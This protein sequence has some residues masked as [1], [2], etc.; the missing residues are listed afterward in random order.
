M[1]NSEAPSDSPASSPAPQPGTLIVP[2]DAPPPAP[3]PVVAPVAAPTSKPVAAQPVPAPAKPSASPIQAASP[4]PTV[5]AP[6]APAASPSPVVPAPLPPVAA[7]LSQPLPVPQPE[8]LAE[9]LA[10][11]ESTPFQAATDTDEDGDSDTDVEEPV[12][13]WTASE[14]IAHEKSAGWYVRLGLAALLGAGLMFLLT[15]DFVSVAVVVVAA[16]LLGVYGSH[17]PRELEYRLGDRGFSI[18]EKV[19]NYDDFRSFSIVP[20]GAFSSIVLLPLKRFGM[21]LTM[22]YPPEEEE[23]IVQLLSDRLPLEEP[24]H[25]RVDSLMRRIRF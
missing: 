23:S 6:I 8:T 19:Y 4:K 12:V 17:K 18:A 16:I 14:F 13:S 22:H 20:E 11:A 15:R 5:A 3:V 2:H 10:A 24:T 25:D 21:Q 7:V 9:T 1:A